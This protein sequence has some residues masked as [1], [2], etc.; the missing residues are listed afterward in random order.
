MI[1]KQNLNKNWS[2]L[3]TVLIDSL[4]E[5]LQ[6][7]EKEWPYMTGAMKADENVKNGIII[8]IE[9][10]LRKAEFYRISYSTKKT[11]DSN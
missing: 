11:K 7:D 6:K 10:E 3:G 4:P 9:E 1:R 2:D 5:V 8:D